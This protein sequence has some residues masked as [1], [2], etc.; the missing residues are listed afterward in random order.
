ME[1]RK[2]PI[3]FDEPR[4]AISG[5]ISYHI[6]SMSIAI[7]YLLIKVKIRIVT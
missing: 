5:V 6:L 7:P 2:K 3:M 1:A 4:R